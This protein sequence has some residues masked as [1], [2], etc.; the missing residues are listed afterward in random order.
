[1]KLFTTIYTLRSKPETGM[2]FDADIFDGNIP[3]G[4]TWEDYEP[5][6][7]IEIP[8]GFE[9]V[10]K[11]GS[12]VFRSKGSFPKEFS[13]NALVLHLQGVKF[14]TDRRRNLQKIIKAMWD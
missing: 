12:F 6:T 1:M 9:L 2:V 5:L 3:E 8:K 7:I 4:T 11:E 13:P 10:K 14:A